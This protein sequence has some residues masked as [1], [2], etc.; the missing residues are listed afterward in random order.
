MLLFFN[1][2]GFN[3]GRISIFLVLFHVYIVIFPYF[4]RPKMKSVH[5]YGYDSM[6][7]MKSKLCGVVSCFASGF[8]S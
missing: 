6:Q 4:C 7:M 2:F 5:L 8:H 1:E 3:G